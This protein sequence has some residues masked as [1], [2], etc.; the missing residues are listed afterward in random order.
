[1]EEILKILDLKLKIAY[2]SGFNDGV[3]IGLEQEDLFFSRLQLNDL[4]AVIKKYAENCIKASLE[5]TAAN[6]EAGSEEGMFY[7]KYESIIDTDN[8]VLL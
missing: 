6:A 5:K 7:V 2:G 3:E 8:I 4:Q 1:M